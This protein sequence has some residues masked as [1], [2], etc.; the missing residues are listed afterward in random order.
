MWGCFSSD[1]IGDLH[2]MKDVSTKEK[3][4]SII[5]RH[6]I[7]SGLSLCGRGCILQQDNEPNH[8]YQFCK[9]YLKK[10]EDQ[11]D[12]VVMDFLPES[13]DL[14]AI[15]HLWDHLKREKMR[16]AVTSQDALWEVIS[17][18]WNTIKLEVIHKLV[19]SM[20]Q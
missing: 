14:N 18:S 11:G 19:E 8:T 1:G 10:K 7:P 12:P 17:G 5:Q 9:N 20:P 6:G 16:H 2:R 4:H 15:E 3:Y 13:P